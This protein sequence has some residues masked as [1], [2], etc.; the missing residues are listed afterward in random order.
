MSY[1]PGPFVAPGSIGELATA[2]WDELGKISSS[3]NLLVLRKEHSPPTKPFEG[4]VVFADGTDWN[5]GSGKGFYG[6][7]GSA[8]VFLG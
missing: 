4:Q 8:W 6:W 3:F 2:V 7:D 1:T 5:P